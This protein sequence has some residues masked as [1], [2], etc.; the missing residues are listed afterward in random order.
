[1]FS[2]DGDFDSSPGV[3]PSQPFQA[4]NHPGYE[5][6]ALKQCLAHAQRQIKTLKGTL[7]RE[8]ELKIEY[9]KRLNVSLAVSSELNIEEYASDEDTEDGTPGSPGRASR[10]AVLHLFLP[11]PVQLPKLFL[12]WPPNFRSRNLRRFLFNPRS[13]YPR[14]PHLRIFVTRPC[15]SSRLPPQNSVVPSS[16]GPTAPITPKLYTRPRRPPR[17]LETLR[18]NY[19]YSFVQ[20]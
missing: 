3:S 18:Y 7:Q 5:V 12:L 16:T 9:R 8:K 15:L 6:E 11:H 10:G 19:P 4:P 1:M 2:A 20:P 14:L 17:L 13:G